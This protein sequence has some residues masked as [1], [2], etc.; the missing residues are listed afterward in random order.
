M[1]SRKDVIG[2]QSAIIVARFHRWGEGMLRIL[3]GLLLAA[4]SLVAGAQEE[5]VLLTRLKALGEAHHGKVALYAENMTSGRVVALNA[6]TPVQTASVIKLAVLYEALQQIRAGK[7]HFEDKITLQHSDQVS[8]SGLL[9]FFDTPH[10]LKFK[11]V[12][13]MM[14]I[15]SDNTATNLAIDHLGLKNIDDRLVSLG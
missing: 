5:Q 8:G 10:E 2:D 14:I 11:D 7:V 6:D 12:L 4:G 3:M 1:G 13:T 9:P 15:V